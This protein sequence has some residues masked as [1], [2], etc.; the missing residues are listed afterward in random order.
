MEEKIYSTIKSMGLD[1]YMVEGNHIQLKKFHKTAPPGEH[2]EIDMICLVNNVCLFIE[3]TRQKDDNRKKIRKF[4]RHCNLITS[5]PLEIKE[6]F[7][8]LGIPSRHLSD[9][10][11][12]E[13]YKFAYFNY[14]SYELIDEDIGINNFPEVSGRLAIFNIY[15]VT[16]LISLTK[17]VKKYA[18][19]EFLS[20]F[21]IPADRSNPIKRVK[22]EF[23]ET[24]NRIL[25]PGVPKANIYL[26]SLKPE[27]LLNT[28]RVFRYGGVLVPLDSS[29]EREES[30]GKYQRI[31]IE[32]KLKDISTDFIKNDR[33]VSFP[34]TVTLV[35]RSRPTFDD[36]GNIIISSDYGSIDI[37]DGQ[38][39]I[40]AYA[41][42]RLSDGVR[43]NSEVFA[44]LISF[45]DIDSSS[46]NEYTSK[47]FFEIN[48]KQTK[49]KR[50]LLY[51]VKYDVLGDKDQVAIAGKIILEINKNGNFK[52]IFLTN[53][54]MKENIL[55]LRPIPIVTIIDE[56]SKMLDIEE[57]SKPENEE[58]KEHFEEI[59]GNDL[60]YFKRYPQKIYEKGKA[61]VDNFF[62][63]VKYVYR[64]DWKENSDSNIL[65]AKYTAAMMR[66]LKY[67]LMERGKSVEEVKTKLEILKTNVR[68]LC[69][70]QPTDETFKTDFEG[71]FKEGKGIPNK[72]SSVKDIYE[73]FKNNLGS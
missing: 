48:S 35:L 3:V 24:K 5:S 25:S 39:R 16:Y 14:E 4:L 23:V 46:L 62:G 9:F 41:N 68:E 51:L 33:R 12:V 32:S 26:I 58:F 64:E 67:F 8:I 43:K 59:F 19:P 60:R 54:L 11:D 27:E 18:K 52:R 36:D 66:F 44:S 53:P 13:D 6:K 1:C 40:F 38:H 30:E 57:I 69:D 17:M 73:F 15:D 71:D 61:I 42:E 37:I 10:E 21:H 7:R 65:C 45:V 20:N 2:L 56:L 72:K 31:L 55:K 28:C 70:A 29:G 22:G 34:T 49:V 47:L 50:N 63:Y